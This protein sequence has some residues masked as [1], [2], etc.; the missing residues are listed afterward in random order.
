MLGVQVEDPETGDGIALV[1]SLQ[2][3]YVHQLVQSRLLDNTRPL[4]DLYNVLHSFCQSLQLEVLQSQVDF[5][6]YK[7]QIPFCPKS[8]LKFYL[9]GNLCMIIH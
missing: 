1:H 8:T 6:V 9:T 7:I 4:H 2:V 3:Q 5:I